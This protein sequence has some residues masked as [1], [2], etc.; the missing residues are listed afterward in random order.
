VL[1]VVDREE[2]WV[3]VVVRWDAEGADTTHVLES[4]NEVSESGLAKRPSVRKKLT[5][6]LWCLTS[7]ADAADADADADA[8]PGGRARKRPAASTSARKLPAASPSVRKR[9][10]PAASVQKAVSCEASEASE[11]SPT[12]AEFQELQ[13]QLAHLRAQS[14]V[15]A[16]AVYDNP[17]NR[18]T[19]QNI[20]AAAL[21]VPA[22]A[23]ADA[24][25]DPLAGLN[26][27]GSQVLCRNF[28]MGI[29]QA[30]RLCQSA[31]EKPPAVAMTP[32]MIKAIRDEPRQF[33]DIV[34]FKEGDTYGVGGGSL[35][36]THM[37]VC[38]QCASKSPQR[39]QHA[40]L[41]LS[42]GNKQCMLCRKI[43]SSSKVQLFENGRVCCLAAPSAESNLTDAFVHKWLT[44][45]KEMLGQYGL[46][47]DF[48]YN[49]DTTGGLTVDVPITIK[50]R[51][52]H[53]RSRMGLELDADQHKDRDAMEEQV[54][55]KKVL[56]GYKDDTCLSRGVIHF[57]TT[58]KFR[59]GERT[60]RFEDTLSR[61]LIAQSW[62]ID[63]VLHREKYPAAWAL[64][65][66]YDDTSPRFAWP[67][68]GGV[69]GNTYMAPKDDLSV[70][71]HPTVA[72]WGSTLD[73]SIL[74]QSHN[75]ACGKKYFSID[76]LVVRREVFGAGFGPQAKCADANDRKLVYTSD[77]LR[78]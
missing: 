78:R 41:G 16:Q 62:V 52:G 54:R 53:V 12:R 3:K 74:V 43:F 15:V 51:S 60:H 65:L 7:P 27:G 23:A 42:G 59:V 46:V 33:L 71:E 22:N 72:D 6:P 38:K 8:A 58:G 67:I 48:C 39:L 20:A 18:Q 57:S 34:R 30:E 2:K 55:V 24:A 28:V 19:M 68:K 35:S 21:P 29:G 17:A 14:A 49:M 26:H 56:A 64:Y 75:H 45:V 77:E 36:A 44:P 73:P 1:S 66:F 76:R 4:R 9:Q 63:A 31:A 10:P 11:A 47:M 5:E 32:Q 69:C 37:M 13:R 50:D 40:L 25:A 70:G 61:W